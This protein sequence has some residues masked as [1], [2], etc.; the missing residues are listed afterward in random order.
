[1]EKLATVNAVSQQAQAEV[2]PEAYP[3]DQMRR[4]RHLLRY[5]MWTLTNHSSIDVQ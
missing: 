3:V 1:M 5:R 4:K 2:D